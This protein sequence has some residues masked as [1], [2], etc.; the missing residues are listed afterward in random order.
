MASAP[1]SQTASHSISP[2]SISWR[3]FE[4]LRKDYHKTQSIEAGFGYRERLPTNVTA[5]P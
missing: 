3:Q 4:E 1:H 2:V 5:V